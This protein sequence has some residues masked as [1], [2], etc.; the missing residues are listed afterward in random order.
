M[1]AS[2]MCLLADT[3]KRREALPGQCAAAAGRAQ[4]NLW[5]EGHRPLERPSEAR[6]AVM[7]LLGLVQG[8][9]WGTR[10]CFH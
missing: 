5:R 4:Q 1:S 3:T 10:Q 7:L 9:G 6:A 2:L 8:A